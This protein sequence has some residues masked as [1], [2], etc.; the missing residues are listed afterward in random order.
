MGAV[1]LRDMHPGQRGRVVGYCPG[2]GVY[3]QKLLSMGLTPGVTFTFLNRAPMGCPVAI[4]LR[5]YTLGLRQA[6]A[7]LLVIERV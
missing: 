5:G 4:A 3:R 1:K 7:D 6:E 2:D